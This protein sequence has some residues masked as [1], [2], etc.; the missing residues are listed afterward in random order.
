MF[1]NVR[2]DD[3]LNDYMYF[4][5]QDVNFIIFFFFF[6]VPCPKG[7]ISCTNNVCTCKT[8]YAG[9]GCCYCAEGV[10]NCSRARECTC[11][12]GYTGPDCCECAQDYEREGDECRGT[13]NIKE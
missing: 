9:P 8:G 3:E 13:Y 2:T 7:V 12:V 10:H 11:K 4:Q 5:F 1:L 6:P